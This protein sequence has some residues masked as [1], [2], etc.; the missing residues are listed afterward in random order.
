MLTIYDKRNQGINP[1][2]HVKLIIVKTTEREKRGKK[3]YLTK[4]NCHDWG[5]FV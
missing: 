4:I 2:F 5:Y 3:Y 1:D